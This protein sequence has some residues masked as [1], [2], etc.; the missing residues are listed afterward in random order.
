MSSPEIDKIIE[1]F[2]NEFD[3]SNTAI[4]IS[5]H[6]PGAMLTLTKKDKALL[7]ASLINDIEIMQEL[8]Y[9][10]ANPRVCDDLILVYAATEGYNDVIEML[11]KHGADICAYRNSSLLGAIINDHRNTVKLLL[12]HGAQASEDILYS[13]AKGN[14]VDIFRDIFSQELLDSCDRALL[15]SGIKG[16]LEIFRIIMVA[17]DYHLPEDIMVILLY[18]KNRKITAELLLNGFDLRS[19]FN[20]E[21]EALFLA[22]KYDVFDDLDRP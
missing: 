21:N 10:G 17:L 11:L 16:H 8:I 18:T 15:I 5:Q 14:H 7:I 20:R 9:V 2:S 1:W 6:I 13:A 12:D 3:G 4:D 22:A 19:G